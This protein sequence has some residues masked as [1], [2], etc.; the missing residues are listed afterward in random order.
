MV[1]LSSH[2]HFPFRNQDIFY[3]LVVR[4]YY[5][6]RKGNLIMW[7]WTL[8]QL[9]KK[10]II[11]TVLLLWTMKK[12]LP[13]LGK[14]DEWLQT[15]LVVWDCMKHLIK[16]SVIYSSRLVE[17]VVFYFWITCM[18]VMQSTL[19]NICLG[20]ACTWYFQDLWLHHMLLWRGLCCQCCVRMAQNWSL[21]HN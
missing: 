6:L 20:I 4:W 5:A 11:H 3:V 8:Y 1:L 18:L 14:T 15:L 12:Y 2:S 21:V 19:L 13:L 9:F 16:A 10:S 7:S 17:C